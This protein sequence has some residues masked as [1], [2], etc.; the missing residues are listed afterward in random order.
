M[1]SICQKSVHAF[2]TREIMARPFWQVSPTSYR[3]VEKETI[4]KTV[5]EK[6]ETK[7]RYTIE[8]KIPDHETDI[9]LVYPNGRRV[10]IQHRMLGPSLDIC[11]D[12]DSLPL[13][14]AN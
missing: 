7:G 13:E 11:F 1:R 2:L 6:T 12:E 10:A 9:I 5:T 4:M 3:S 14:C 8:V